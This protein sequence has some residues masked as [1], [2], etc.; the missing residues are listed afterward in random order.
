MLRQGPI[1]PLSPPQITT[2]LPSGGIP[3][4]VPSSATPTP[5]PSAP[6]GG[7]KTLADCMTFWDRQTH[8]TKREWRDACQRSV[9]R[10]E[11]LKVET[12]LP[13]TKK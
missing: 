13:K 4:G 10:L 9:T 1:A 6:G 8:M 7:G 11:N 12:L 5:S 3:T 2:T